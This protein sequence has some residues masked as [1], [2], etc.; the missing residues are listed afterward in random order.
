MLITRC[1]GDF[2]A[3]GECLEPFTKVQLQERWGPL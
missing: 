3:V 1:Q 2:P